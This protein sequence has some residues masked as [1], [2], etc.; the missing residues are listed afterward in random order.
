M[1][2]TLLALALAPPAPVRPARR[3][4]GFV[5]P[6]EVDGFVD[7]AGWGTHRA[8]ATLPLL[9]FLPG[10]DGSLATCLFQFPALG[11]AFE[12]ACMRHADGMGSRAPF[13]AL[14]DDAASFVADACEA[15]R[16]VVLVGESFGATLAL[17]V[18]LRLAEARTRVAGV[19]LVNPATPYP[20]S[21]LA[22]LGPPLAAL[23]NPLFLLGLPLLALLVF[24]LPTQ[25][26]AFASVLRST[27][28]PALLAS[29]AREA[30]LGR[31]ALA[32]FLGRRGPNLAI[33][34]LL[35]LDVFAPDDLSFRLSR[36]LRDGAAAVEP[37]LRE[38]DAPVLC[39]VG[40]RDRLLPSVDEAD[41][42]RARLRDLRGTVVVP[43]AGHASTLGPALNLT[44]AIIGAFGDELR[45][46]GSAAG[47]AGGSA[48]AGRV[49]RADLGAALGEL[50]PGAAEWERGMVA[51]PFAPLAVGDY[52][53][54][55]RGGALCP[56]GARR[57]APAGA[58]P[59]GP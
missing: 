2:V 39:V 36:W 42:L 49:P 46:A 59:A 50:A 21:A 56:E 40:G 55:N 53:R 37:R 52:A 28:L 27:R 19:V 3:R 54:Y 25:I 30:Y 35:A 43:G 57:G 47:A 29:P 13:E 44:S 24:D 18:A 5:N 15:G 11:A 12:L 48:R 20:R 45:G 32:A 8:P 26:P 58:A 4:V 31:V 33:G 16:R 7:P 23:P 17:G 51:R 38:V 1:L 22:R 34:P 41:R 10:M 9:V 14:V 6:L